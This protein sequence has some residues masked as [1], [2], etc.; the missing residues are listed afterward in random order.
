LVANF[1]VPFFDLHP[2][3]RRWYTAV[4]LSV[5]ASAF[6]VLC[7]RRPIQ[8]RFC[9]GLAGP[10][11]VR[12]ICNTSRESKLKRKKSNENSSFRHAFELT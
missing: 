7:A 1:S 3:A 9:F 8:G 4:N 6:S 10:F 11:H 12:H 5:R 2:Y